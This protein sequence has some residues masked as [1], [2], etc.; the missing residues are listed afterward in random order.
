MISGGA[1]VGQFVSVVERSDSI[2]EVEESVL[3]VGGSSTR[4]YGR[5][6]TVSVVARK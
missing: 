2:W 6:L 5:N 1:E 3:V 4:W